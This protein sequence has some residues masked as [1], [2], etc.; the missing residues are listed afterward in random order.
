MINEKLFHPESI[1]VIGGSNNISKPGGKI[2][3]NLV[4]NDFKGHIYPVNPKESE[5]Q[6]LASFFEVDNLPQT[7]LA[8][9]AIPAK[10]CLEAVSVLAEEKDTKAF[11]IISAGFGE[12]SEEGKK[13]ADYLENLSPD[14]FGK[15]KV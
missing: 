2:I 10:F 5:V 9:L 4:D 12:T 11:I 1:A 6:G 8:I 7:D 15:Y 14:D 13:W 3:K